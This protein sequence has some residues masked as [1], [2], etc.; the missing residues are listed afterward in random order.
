[1]KK[2]NIINVFVNKG[3]NLIEN[4]NINF[5]KIDVEGSELEVLVGLQKL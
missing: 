1:M 5:I 4:K 3:D 2:L